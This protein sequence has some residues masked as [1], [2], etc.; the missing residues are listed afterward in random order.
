MKKQFKIIAGLTLP[1][2]VSC[3][4]KISEKN[5]AS[6]KTV[7]VSYGTENAN[8]S[9]DVCLNKLADDEI[10]FYTLRDSIKPFLSEYELDNLDVNWEKYK[11]DQDRNLQSISSLIHMFYEVFYSINVYK[12]NINDETTINLLNFIEKLK[13]KSIES[14]DQFKFEHDLFSQSILDRNETPNE[15]TTFVNQSLARNIIEIEARNQIKSFAEVIDEIKKENNLSSNYVF[16]FHELKAEIAT[17]TPVGSKVHKDSVASEPAP[18]PHNSEPSGMSNINPHPNPTPGSGANQNRTDNIAVHFTA[19]PATV[20]VSFINTGNASVNASDTVI[21]TVKNRTLIKKLLS[22]KDYFTKNLK[23]LKPHIKAENNALELNSDFNEGLV[24]NAGLAMSAIWDFLSFR[25]STKDGVSEDFE[26]LYKLLMAHSYLGFTQMGVD[27]LAATSD[28]VHIYQTMTTANLEQHAEVY[29]KLGRVFNAASNVISL[30]S[31]A[32]DAAKIASSRTVTEKI[33]F[34]TQ[35]SFDSLG[36]GLGVTNLVLRTLG[37][38]TASSVLGTI[39]VPIAGLSV[40]FTSFVAASAQAQEEAII[41]ARYI[42]DYEKD[43]YNYNPVP[44]NTTPEFIALPYKNIDIHA[45]QGKIIKAD[46]TNVVINSIDTREINKV[47]LGYG[48]HKIYET[49]HNLNFQHCFL[50]CNVSA[51]ID[52][53]KAISISDVLKFPIKE[54]IFT[55]SY[56][57]S[58]ILPIVPESYI[59]YTYNYTPFILSRGDAELSPMR[60][61]EKTGKF[62][63]DYM[64]PL[65]FEHAIRNLTSTFVD[66]NVNINLGGSNTALVTPLM[67][68]KFYGKMKYKVY[69]EDGNYL[70]KVLDTAKYEINISGHEKWFIDASE[71][72]YKND[73]FSLTESLLKIG[74]LEISFPSSKQPQELILALN[75]GAL[76][77]LDLINKTRKL[78]VVNFSM[79]KQNYPDYL[80]KLSELSKN[81]DNS[82]KYIELEHYQIEGGQIKAWYDINKNEIFYPR[83]PIFDFDCENNQHCIDINSVMLLERRDKEI[84]YYSNEK[85]SFYYQENETE[86]IRVISEGVFRV[87]KKADNSFVIENAAHHIFS[88]SPEKGKI[89]HAVKKSNITVQ[90]LEILA[91]TYGYALADKVSIFNSE[92]KFVGYFDNAKKEIIYVNLVKQSDLKN[93]E[94]NDNLALYFL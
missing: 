22:F 75:D 79:F 86:S 48:S 88:F 89:L 42:F 43:H 56:N 50:F 57:T 67:P 70:I 19:E 74:N 52:K 21:V 71:V 61:L 9:K 44:L 51:N 30:A 80:A 5:G 14:I 29:S 54:T 26:T 91:S 49:K 8:K 69:G 31:I 11:E 2:L 58:I 23:I 87:H 13:T 16:L 90:G 37:A 10:E 72:A 38:T 63:F 45:S 53:D 82:L 46:F 55:S 12:N 15:D 18:I 73:S 62:I 81:S 65:L 84:F 4:G 17:P 83:N 66:T 40:G 28:F 85:K 60:R 6:T 76:Y 41:K 39:S 92:E 78:L 33:E 27:S 25:K 32:L 47:K 1:L 20:Q 35:L 59:S 7:G 94:V 77:H 93:M 3:E 34:S 36:L 68:Q 24:L 64:G